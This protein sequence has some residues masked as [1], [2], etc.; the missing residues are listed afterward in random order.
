MQLKRGRENIKLPGISNTR[1][2]PRAVGYKKDPDT[3][4]E[5]NVSP[6]AEAARFKKLQD[7]IEIAEEELGIL[8]KNKGDQ[9]FA[10]NVSRQRKLLN[11]L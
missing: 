2:Q 3:L 8:R 4:T 5:V 9:L 1:S 6:G 10:Q 7:Q 11:H